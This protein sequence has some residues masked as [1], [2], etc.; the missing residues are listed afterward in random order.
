MAPEGTETADGTADGTATGDQNATDQTTTPIDGAATGTP[1]TTDEGTAATT[2]DTSATEGAGGTPTEYTDFTMPEGVEVNATLL[3][4]ATPLFQELGLDQDQAQKLVDFYATKEQSDAVAAQT[5][6]GEMLT[7]WE[8]ELKND[9]DFG[10][11]NFDQNIALAK[12]GL[13]AF[14]GAELAKELEDTG[15][16]SNPHLVR[17]FQ[18]I[19]KAIQEDDPQGNR[20]QAGGK[21][22]LIDRLYPNNKSD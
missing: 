22:S 8:N 4:S 7:N 12:Q 18:R 19:G 10:G 9:A 6:Y 1:P 16:G 11:E 13:E 15:F 17:A 21:Q 20:T 5:T 14:G 3:E 2:G